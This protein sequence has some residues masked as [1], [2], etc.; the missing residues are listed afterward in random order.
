M[1]VPKTLDDLRRIVKERLEETTWLEFKRQLPGSG[2]NNDIAKDLAAFANAEG[3]VIIYGI[4]EDNAGRA[5]ALTPFPI[6]G[7]GERVT[8]VAQRL[9]E[10]LA[11]RSVTTVLADGAADEGFVI[12][13]VPPSERAPHLFRGLALGRTSK[14]NAP[15][16]RRQTG[17]LF[18]RS[19]GFAE[20]F[21]LTASKP[22]RVAVALQTESYQESSGFDG[23]IG[24]S[25]DYYLAFEN[26]GDDDVFEAAWEWI[27]PEKGKDPPTTIENPFPIDVLPPGAR[28][29]VRV[30]I[31]INDTLNCKVRTRWQDKSG[32][33]HEQTWPITW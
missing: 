15:L 17:E 8:L 3:G 31:G 26:D 19:P 20:E 21:G 22:G 16:T 32:K 10:T 6:S 25:W 1:F 23:G 33:Q 2:N 29:R 27:T 18:A 24:T 5:K 9:D 28:A 4:E 14:G 30:S 12:V 7:V 11:L 13:E